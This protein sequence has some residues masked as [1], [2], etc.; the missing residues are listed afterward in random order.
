[1]FYIKFSGIQF[2]DL[3]YSLYFHRRFLQ[4]YFYYDGAVFNAITSQ[5]ADLGAE[6]HS[7]LGLFCEF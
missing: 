5:E 6:P 7:Q 1:M 3:L 4:F 2:Y